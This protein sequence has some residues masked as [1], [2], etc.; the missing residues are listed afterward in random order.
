MLPT[1]FQLGFRHLTAAEAWDHQLF[2]LTIALAYA[3]VLW[4]KWIVLATVFALGH[5]LAIGLTATGVLP[6]GMTWIE[7]GIA[8]SIVV[9]AL[10][11]LGYLMRDPYGLRFRKTKYG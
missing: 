5:T 9:L 11:D 1:F 10:V 8:G 7:P 2:L 3:P 6:V 4:R